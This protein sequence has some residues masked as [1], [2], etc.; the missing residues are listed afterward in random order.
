GLRGGES[1]RC[2]RGDTVVERA[3]HGGRGDIFDAAVLPRRFHQNLLI[4]ARDHDAPRRPDFD[5]SGFGILGTGL[6]HA[7]FEPALDEL[8]ITRADLE[9]LAAAVLHQQRRLLQEDAALRITHDDAPA[10]RALHDLGVIEE[11]IEA[12]QTELE[13]A[14]AM[15]SAVAGALIA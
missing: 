13:S 4:L 2:D 3:E 5:R 15:L 1:G 6:R 14:A 8:V 10:L 11:R 7:V 9:A 12:E